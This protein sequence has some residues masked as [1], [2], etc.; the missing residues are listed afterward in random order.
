V[1]THCQEEQYIFR[2]YYLYLL[3]RKF[4]ERSFRVRLAQITYIDTEGRE[5][6]ETKWAFFIESEE[7]MAARNDGSPLEEDIVLQPEEVDRDHLTLCHMFNYMIANRD[8]RV[9]EYQNLKIITNG[10]EKP[11]VVPYDFDWSGMVNASY[12]KRS[13]DDK[14]TYDKRQI[15]RSLCRTEEEYET[16]IERFQAMRDEIEEMYETS[17]YLTKEVKK[18]SLGYYSDFYKLIRKKSTMRKVLLSGCNQ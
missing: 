5:P 6:T 18:E 4:T 10:S 8:F 7:D 17:P 3:Y 16:L 2:E 13:G 12:T 1:V 15:F 11:V 9:S 14:P